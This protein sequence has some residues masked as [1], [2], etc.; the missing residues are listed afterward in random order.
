M[1]DNR[2]KIALCILSDATG[3]RYESA[4]C[5]NQAVCPLELT[6]AEAEHCPCKTRVPVGRIGYYGYRYERSRAAHQVRVLQCLYPETWNGDVIRHP[7]AF[8]DYV[9]HKARS[10]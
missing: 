3:G 8:A 1:S 2:T 4:D 6:K 5:H 9:R 7:K 10:N